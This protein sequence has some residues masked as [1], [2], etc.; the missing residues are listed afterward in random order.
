MS[1]RLRYFIELY[2]ELTLQDRNVCMILYTRQ[3]SCIQSTRLGLQIRAEC[4]TYYRKE[5][6]W[7]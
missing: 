1:F 7:M 2:E 6:R 5:P 3:I 4:R